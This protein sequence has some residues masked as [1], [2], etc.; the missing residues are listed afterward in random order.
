MG[1]T[2]ILPRLVGAGRAAELM[3]LGESIAP[4][5]AERI[6]LVNEVVPRAELMD[7]VMELAT[8]LADGPR[9]R[10]KATKKALFLSTY[11][12]LSAHM[13]YE[14]AAQAHMIRAGLEY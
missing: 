9:L 6:G 4:D 11:D 8:K 12:R 5:K 7:K 13:E 14:A 2:W 10:L 3:F 1:L